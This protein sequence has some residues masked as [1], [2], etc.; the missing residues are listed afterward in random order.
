MSAFFVFFLIHPPPPPPFFHRY[1]C[2]R[3]GILFA[4][5]STYAAAVAALADKP[6]LVPAGTSA[7]S[8]ASIVMVDIEEQELAQDV[9]TRAETRFIFLCT[10]SHRRH[11]L[12]DVTQHWYATCQNYTLLN[13]PV[14][15]EF[16]WKALHSQGQVEESPS[17]AAIERIQKEFSF[18][19]N[20]RPLLKHR[21]RG[22]TADPR[23]AGDAATGDV[24][25]ANGSEGSRTARGSEHSTRSTDRRRPRSARSARSARL[26]DRPMSR[27]TTP[28]VA[29][30]RLHDGHLGSSGGGSGG[31]GGAATQDDARDPSPPPRHAMETDGGLGDV[32]ALLQ[33]QA[34][35][36]PEPHVSPSR[37]AILLAEDN[38]INVKVS[39][40]MGKGGRGSQ[41][42]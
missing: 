4:S 34:A 25:T 36:F 15:R 20:D 24:A 6:K 35:P 37:P 40:V 13:K 10:D 16:L 27:P 32:G 31:N 42:G 11:L 12:R 19:R 3:W 39:M 29:R 5:G 21:P 41:V 7:E 1:A 8:V 26:S 33:G 2:S 9:I 23:R 18:R 14:K 30:A 22:G 17:T 28:Q 38:P